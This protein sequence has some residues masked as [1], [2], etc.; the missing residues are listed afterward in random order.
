MICWRLDRGCLGGGWRGIDIVWRRLIRRECGRIREGF[1]GCIG[2]DRRLIRD[3]NGFWFCGCVRFRRWCGHVAGQVTR[4][5]AKIAAAK[6]IRRRLFDR[7]SRFRISGVFVRC[8]S[9]VCF[10]FR[11]VFIGRRFRFAGVVGLVR[12]RFDVKNCVRYAFRCRLRFRGQI[13]FRSSAIEFVS[14]AG[15]GAGHVILS[16][17][18]RIGLGERIGVVA[19]VLDQFGRVQCD[20]GLCFRLGVY[21]FETLEDGMDRFF[22]APSMPVGF[23]IQFSHETAIGTS[24]SIHVV[25]KLLRRAG[26]DDLAERIRQQDGMRFRRQDD[27]VTLGIMGDR[28]VFAL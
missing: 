9:A 14:H 24:G 15:D 10:D 2:L 7:R 25:G 5:G 28:A 26:F 1:D 16:L 19:R 21:G 3:G 12:F 4:S 17:D 23:A 8:A 27:P 13:R 11:S 20:L 18:L 6:G 22:G